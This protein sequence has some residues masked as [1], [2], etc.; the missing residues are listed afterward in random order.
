MEALRK[1]VCKNPALHV[2]GRSGVGGGAWGKHQGLPPPGFVCKSLLINT[3]H[4]DDVS[5]TEPQ[6]ADDAGQLMVSWP[7]N[8]LSVD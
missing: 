4:Q 1:P 5:S 7:R 8:S 3:T 2:F 6:R